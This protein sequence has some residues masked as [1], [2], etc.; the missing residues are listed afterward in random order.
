MTDAAPV[1]PPL[2]ESGDAKKGLS[3]LAWIAIG[4]GTFLVVGFAGCMALGVFVFRTGQEAVREATGSE[5]LGDF[6]DGLRDDPARTAAEALI[7]LNPELDLISTDEAAGSITFRNNRTNEEA[8]LNFEDIAEGRFSMTTA[9]G[10]LSI[11]ADENADGAAS[12]TLSG[13]D[14]ET[15]FGGS[16]SLAD[17]PGWVPGY[18]RGSDTQSAFQTTSGETRSGAISSTTTD[19]ARTV[20][21]YYKGVLEDAGYAISAESLTQA[22]TGAIGAVSGELDAEG[23]SITVAA[24]EQSGETQVMVTYTER[25]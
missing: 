1:P 14:S 21:D 11:D 20:V 5:S 2:P 24:V 22:G 15:R 17:V 8:T 13:R 3:P 23:R 16:A 18:A 4:V 9:E 19:P 7:R 12:V 25:P 6:V 10:E